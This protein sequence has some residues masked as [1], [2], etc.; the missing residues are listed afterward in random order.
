MRNR[1][2]IGFILIL[3]IAISVVVGCQQATHPDNESISDQSSA[4]MVE[5]ALEEAGNPIGIAHLS[6]ASMEMRA[7]SNV[8]DPEVIAD[9]LLL[10]SEDQ[11]SIMAR[12]RVAR[13]AEPSVVLD[14]AET[15]GLDTSNPEAIEE[16]ILMSPV[17]MSWG[18]IKCC[19]KDPECCPPPPKE[20][21]Q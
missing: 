7:L 18:A 16:G 13:V 14:I 5:A 20:K 6:I 1:T 15:A 17:P 8:D 3:S 2:Y 9:I 21:D 10:L 12:G 11:L 19:Y 4:A